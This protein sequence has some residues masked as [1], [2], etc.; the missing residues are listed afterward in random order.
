MIMGVWRE[1]GGG[2]RTARGGERRGMKR[3]GSL[4]TVT[5]A[6][7]LRDLRALGL[8]PGDTV[9]VHSA[10]SRIGFIPGG[11]PAVVA[12]FREVLGPAGTLAVPT[13]P[14]RGSM[15]DYVQSDPDF[16]VEET[17]SLMGAISEAVRVHPEARRSLEP[18]HPVSA[19]GPQ[20]AFLL[21]EHLHGEGPCD[22]HSPLY[23]LT[24]VDGYVLLLG[25]DSRNCTLLHTAEE[26]AR[27]PFIDFETRYRL[28][29]RYRGAAYALSIYCHTAPLRARF[30]AIEAPLRQRGLLTLG[31]VGHAE[32]RLAR[33]RDILETALEELRRNPTFL[34]E[35]A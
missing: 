11:A 22:A 9:L 25:V 3:D 7:I 24:Q 6:E 21:E 2:G 19:I 4:P 1:A 34:R 29:G 32:C 12:A 35:S 30:S 18:T 23:R 13:F 27:V 28:C 33:A 10:M 20:S 16:C 8:R 31:R 14:F 26:I 5:A 15:L 17:P